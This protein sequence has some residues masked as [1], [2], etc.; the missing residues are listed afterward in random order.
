MGSIRRRL[1]QAD[2]GPKTVIAT[3]SVRLLGRGLALLQAIVLARILGVEQF[4]IFTLAIAWTVVLHSIAV[5]GF[6]GLQARSVSIYEARGEAAL[7]RGLLRRC[8]EITLLAAGATAG[9]GAVGAII[10]VDPDYLAAILIGLPLVPLRSLTLLRQGALRGLHRAELSLSP[11]LVV[12]PGVLSLAALGFDLAG[13]ELDARWAVALACLGA[14]AALAFSIAARHRHLA[15]QIPAAEPRFSTREW[16][17][18]TRPFAISGVIRAGTASVGLIALGVIGSAADAGELRVL[19]RGA[20]L[21]GIV[22]AA[23]N[24]PLGPL[25]ARHQALD[26]DASMRTAIRR[27]ART[28][29]ALSLPLGLALLLFSDQL[30][31]LFGDGFVGNRGVFA[32]LIV[33][34][35]FNAAIG[36]SMQVHLMTGEGA[37][38]VRFTA[39]A[40]A[41][42]LALCLALIPPFGLYGAAI[43]WSADLILANSL[44]AIHA[45][46]RLAI[47]LTPFGPLQRHPAEP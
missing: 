21:I 37:I 12:Y 34:S 36:P 45:W 30:F 6:D 40:L 15:L 23:V 10:A 25:I 7:L 46:Q 14:A 9:L 2:G 24:T 8:D 41:L 47:N 17:V 44:L 31:A 5:L 28:S 18:A 22:L 26:E 39:V 11:T 16:L 19:L 4:G 29:L 33:G 20:E 35:L 43:A 27:G 3:L 32:V 13:I 38:A 1:S 42:D